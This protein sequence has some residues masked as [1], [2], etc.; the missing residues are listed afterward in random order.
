MRKFILMTA[1]LIAAG[2]TSPT[3]GTRHPSGTTTTPPKPSQ[4]SRYNHLSEKQVAA[5]AQTH[6]EG[7]ALR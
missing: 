1:C 2:C 4:A 3:P 5:R 7:E 6:V